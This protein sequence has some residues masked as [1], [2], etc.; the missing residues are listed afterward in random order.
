[1]S[2]FIFWLM[3]GETN[4]EELYTTGL[5][6]LLKTALNSIFPQIYV[7]IYLL[8]C[9]QII[10]IAFALAFFLPSIILFLACLISG[11]NKGFVR[12]KAFEKIADSDES[13][14][15]STVYYKSWEFG[16]P[17]AF[18]LSN[19]KVYIGYIVG[20]AGHLNDVLV[21]PL[22]SGYRC[23]K[24]QRLELVTN[25]EPVWNDISDN[26]KQVELSKF[27]ICLPIREVIHANLH[28]FKYKDVFKKHE[29]PRA[30]EQNKHG[31]Y[32]I[33]GNGN[34]SKRG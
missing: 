15:F 9:I 2:A 33:D 26:N 28:D 25:Y 3:K 23:E 10:A 18:T 22:K 6:G 11:K 8:H 34:V 13:P 7:P 29:K 30:V 12:A 19:R 1:M 17:V 32:S 14:E 24:E 4:A 31:S 21:L 5:N 20:S 27:L 16:L